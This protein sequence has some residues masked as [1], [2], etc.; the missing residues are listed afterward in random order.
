[1]PENTVVPTDT[2]MA[3]AATTVSARVPF[4]GPAGR[5]WALRGAAR[6]RDR[7]PRRAWRPSCPRPCRSARG[8]SPRASSSRLPPRSSAA[9]SVSHRGHRRRRPGGLVRGGMRS[10]ARA[11]GG[12]YSPAGERRPPCGGRRAPRGGCRGSCGADGDAGC[13]VGADWRGA[14]PCWSS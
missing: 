2:A 11:R 3:A 4:E 14:G 7:A 5:A 13:G 10:P 6:S 9:A 1:M 8:A 12:M